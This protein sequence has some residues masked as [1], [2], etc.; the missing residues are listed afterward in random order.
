MQWWAWVIIWAGLGLCL[1]GM[2]AF[3]A[4][5]LF[6]KAMR[7]LGELTDLGEKVANISATVTELE[8]SVS[9][10]AILL[11]YPVMSRRREVVKRRRDDRKQLRRE[12]TLERGK[13]LV[14]TDFRQRT[15]PHAR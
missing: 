1:V 14:R 7:T 13:L 15:W 3:F 11:G 12:K 2:L 6:R 4:V 10:N 9:D 5:R 8:L